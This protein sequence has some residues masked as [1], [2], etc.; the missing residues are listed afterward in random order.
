M[1]RWKHQDIFSAEEYLNLVRKYRPYV[2][3]VRTE[4]EY[5]SGHLCGA[6]HIETPLPPVVREDINRLQ[7]DLERICA[8]GPDSL[9]V[10][11]CKLGKRAGL[12]KNIL[13]SLGYRNVLSL[14][15]VDEP[16]LK[17]I[18]AGRNDK[19]KVCRCLN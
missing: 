13:H 12:A 6:Y 14:G 10:V 16:P 3:D 7:S 5:C 1:K 17:S 2:L 18:M 11:Y 4:E 8:Q 19:I 9:I 15:G